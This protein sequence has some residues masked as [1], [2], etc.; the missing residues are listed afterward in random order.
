MSFGTYGGVVV[1]VERNIS[2]NGRYRVLIKPDQDE[3]AWPDVVRAGSGANT[4]ALLNNVPVWYEIW[5]QING[6][7][8]DY[9]LPESDGDL[10]D[11][12]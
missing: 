7:P 3:Q 2:N 1:A 6:F 12:I 9:Y 5:R 11:K 8:P 10:K 4:F